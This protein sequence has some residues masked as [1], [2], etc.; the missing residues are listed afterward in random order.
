MPPSA[1]LRV[2]SP[3]TPA[4]PRAYRNRAE[5][6]MR[7]DL[8][9]EAVEDISRALAFDQRRVEDY[10]ARGQ[11]Y[12]ASGNSAAAATDFDKVIELDP[13]SSMAISVARRQNA[14]RRCRGRFD[15]L[16]SRH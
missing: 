8:S 4:L 12:L 5:A 1:I 11:A 13:K 2:P 9:V 3:S 7:L 14:H 6:D 10:L 16:V 15:R